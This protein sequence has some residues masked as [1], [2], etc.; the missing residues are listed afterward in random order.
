MKKGISYDRVSLRFFC[1]H[2][3]IATLAGSVTLVGKNL[4]ISFSPN[5]V[6]VQK[7]Y[8]RGS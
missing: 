3:G 2:A 6:D 8:I 4:Q 5:K 7:G 1:A